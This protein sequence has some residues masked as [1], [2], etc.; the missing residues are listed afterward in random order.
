MLLSLPLT[1]LALCAQSGADLYH[2][3]G[4]Y[5]NGALGGAIAAIEDLTGDGINEILIGGERYS[6]SASTLLVS[7]ADGSLLHS[8]GTPPH[9]EAVA[10]CG[11][12]NGDGVHDVIIGDIFA[13]ATPI[14][15][16]KAWVYSGAAPYALIYEF[17]GTQADQYLGGAVTGMGDLNG[18]GFDDFAIGSWGKHTPTAFA[19]MV[20]IHSGF[21]GNVI[22]TINGTVDHGYF[23]ESISFIADADGDGLNDLL[24][25]ATGEGSIGRE[26]VAYL[27]SGGSGALLQ[28]WQGAVYNDRMGHKV[29]NA[30]DVNGDGIGDA[31]VS[32]FFAGG[33]GEAFV[34]SG[35][36]GSELI[37]VR[38]FGPGEVMGRSLAGGYDLDSDG[39]DDFM[40]GSDHFYVS[41]GY[42]GFVRVFSGRTGDMMQLYTGGSATARLGVGVEMLGDVNGDGISD[43]AAGAMDED[44]PNGAESGRVFV[45]SGVRKGL[46]LEVRDLAGGDYP[47]IRLSGCSSTSA[48]VFA[49]SLTGPGPSGSPFGPVD[50]TPPITNLPPISCNAD[51]T[52]NLTLGALN[53]SASGM[54]VWA[55]AAELY[56]AGGGQLSHSLALRVR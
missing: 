23:G 28:S 2:I 50:L 52:A 35:A 15:A 1:L 34:Y 20:Q 27:Y 47:A 29:A 13:P 40:V 22:Q 24:I 16:G 46:L 53:P 19:G 10:D 6:S 33:N 41:G 38:G 51:G 56:A 9:G 49:Y 8:F 26:G 30:G 42:T 36:D 31:L 18:D 21:D 43:L 45:Y 3:D 4:Q 54:L 7:G 39:H 48:A 5:A 11:D 37:R 44:T 32:A 12:V 25:G 17:V 14:K 55:Q